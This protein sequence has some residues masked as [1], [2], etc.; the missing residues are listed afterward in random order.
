[1]IP[2]Y[3]AAVKTVTFPPEILSATIITLFKPGNPPNIPQHFRP[4]SLLN[5]DI[6]LYAK[7]IENRLAKSLPLLI[8]QDQM[9]FVTGCQVPDTTRRMIYLIH[10]SEVTKRPPLLQALDAEKAFDRIYWGYRSTVLDKFG[11]R[12]HI[13]SA[14]CALYSRPSAHV[15]SDGL[16]SSPFDITNGTKLG[17]PLSPP[18]HGAIGR[19]D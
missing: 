15:L 11:I 18:S 13:H 8:K 17:C 10:I 9:G 5:V 3:N 7:F 14:I 19:E 6:K 2:V 1:M 16:F 12:R 4:I